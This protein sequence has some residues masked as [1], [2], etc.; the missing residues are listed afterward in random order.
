MAKRLPSSWIRTN[1]AY[2]QRSIK[3]MSYATLHRVFGANIRV[4]SYRGVNTVGWS[5]RVIKC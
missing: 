3:G 1:G 4:P 5:F 2:L